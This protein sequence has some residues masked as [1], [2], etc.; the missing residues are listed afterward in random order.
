MVAADVTVKLDTAATSIQFV[1]V[2]QRFEKTISQSNIY[3]FDLFK[4]SLV[5]FV[6]N[7]RAFGL[8]NNKVEVAAL[9]LVDVSE[10]LPGAE[11]RTDS[12]PNLLLT[13]ICKDQRFV[14]LKFLSRDERNVMLSKIR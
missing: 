12:D 2:Q 9:R 14:V 7:R 3:F 1:N 8:F 4:F 11:L 13:I 5:I 6:L 10:C